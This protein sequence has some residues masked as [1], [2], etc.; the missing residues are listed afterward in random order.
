MKLIIL[1][2]LFTVCYSATI[3]PFLKEQFEK[4]LKAW[5]D[6]KRQYTPISYSYTRPDYGPYPLGNITQ[7][8]QF[9][10][11]M[12]NITNDEFQRRRYLRYTRPRVIKNNRSEAWTEETPQEVGTHEHGAPLML[13]EEL[14]QECLEKVLTKDPVKN[15]IWFD[16]HENGVLRTCHFS[17]VTCPDYCRRGVLIETLDINN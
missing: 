2:L 12:I 3:N 10:W 1:T 8:R 14:Y 5:E 11:T 15:W 13:I 9:N 16:T 4:S 7:I 17:E 6:L